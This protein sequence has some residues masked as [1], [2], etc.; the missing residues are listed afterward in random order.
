MQPN[1]LPSGI[2]TLFVLQSWNICVSEAFV[3]DVCLLN[4]E[5]L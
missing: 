4:N 5:S 3:E 2:S 1:D